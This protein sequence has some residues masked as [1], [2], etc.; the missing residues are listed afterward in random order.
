MKRIRA[1]IISIALPIGILSAQHL[2]QLDTEGIDRLLDNQTETVH[3]VNFWATW[4]SPCVAEI[5]YF[6]ELHKKYPEST[7]QVILVNLDFPNHVE[8]RVLPFIE[9]KGLTADIYNV[10]EMDYN[11]WIPIVDENW[12][13]ALPATLIFKGKERKFFEQEFTRQELFSEVN[14]FLKK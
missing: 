13:G 2:E 11:K 9:E 7:L 10:T 1:I 12:S 4:C 14:E 8:K 6:E 3:V 5:G